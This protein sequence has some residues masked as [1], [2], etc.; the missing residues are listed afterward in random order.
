VEAKA[1][2]WEQALA[3]L[4]KHLPDPQLMLLHAA[5]TRAAFPWEW[6][7]GDSTS[8][9]QGSRKTL[10]QGAPADFALE[11]QR[12]AELDVRVPIYT[13]TGSFGK[14]TTARLLAQML[15]TSGL[16]LGIQLSDGAW[17]AGEQI[18]KGDCINARA[19]MAVLRR[20]EVDVAVLEFGRGGLIDHGFPFDRVDVA[21]LLNLGE[22]HLGTGGVDTLEQMA[23]VKALTLK[24]ARVAVLNHNDAQC[25]R[26]GGRP[27]DGACVWFS[28]LAAADELRQLSSVSKGALGVLRDADGSPLALEIWRG[29][30][31]EKGLKLDGVAPH[32]GMLGE[33]TLEE[34]LA[35]VAAAWFGPVRLDDFEALLPRLRL[36]NAN[37]RFR[38]SSHSKGN[39][40]FVLDKAAERASLAMLQESL[41]GI[42][43][44]DG[45]TRRIAVI[46]RSPAELPAINLESCIALHPLFDE[47][48]C[49]DRPDSYSGEKALP[50]YEPGSISLML[51]SELERLNRL[52]GEEKPIRASGSWDEAEAYLRERLTSLD[53]MTMVL[54]NQPTT[55]A[56]ALNARIISFVDEMIEPA[57]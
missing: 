49:F 35:A 20:P 45:V 44:R 31:R 6:H 47:F 2:A 11:I 8:V 57:A 25:R 21:V 19:A 14:T 22:F 10:L 52:S 26:I 30:V 37:H 54:I 56:A 7:G 4:G 3:L 1:R 39:L 33:K 55:G 42:C 29:G 24:P 48:I 15:E 50:I 46:A 32:Q 23:E 16:R 36:D 41:E 13:I 12:L 28:T 5:L 18:F 34:L 53:A 51:S 27:D 43:E 38:T 40:L 17:A 9:G